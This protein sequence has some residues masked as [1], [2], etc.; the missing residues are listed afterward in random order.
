MAVESSPQFAF[1]VLIL[2]DETAGWI[3]NARVEGG[4]DLGSGEEIAE[5]T[6][7]SLRVFVNAVYSRWAGLL[8]G[9]GLANPSFRD[10]QSSLIDQTVGNREARRDVEAV[11]ATERY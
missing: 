3:R 4:P 5:V 2:N 6:R 7:L 1:A 11:R 9:A 8:L 10:S